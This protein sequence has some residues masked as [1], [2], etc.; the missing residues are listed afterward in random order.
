MT[1]AI[2]TPCPVIPFRCEPACT[3]SRLVHT[4]FAARRAVKAGPDAGSWFSL[5]S[6]SA[7]LGSARPAR[8]CTAWLRRAPRARLRQQ[9]QGPARSGSSRRARSGRAPQARPIPAQ[10][11][12]GTAPAGVA[13]THPKN[14]GG[15]AVSQA[16]RRHGA[17]SAAPLSTGHPR[18]HLPGHGHS[19]RR[20]RPSP[21]QEISPPLPETAPPHREV[22]TTASSTSGRDRDRTDLAST[23]EF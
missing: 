2:P 8:R 9:K 3:S 18:G 1:C 16:H 12:L 4:Q 21:P 5:P 11:T 6:S 20:S 14:S 23:R 7:R 13:P 19:I 10:A 17:C 22:S 15:S